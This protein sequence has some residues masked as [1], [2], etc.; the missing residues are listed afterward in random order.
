MR[1]GL[2]IDVFFVVLFL[3]FLLVA[4][5]IDLKRYYLLDILTLPLLWLGL[6]ANLDA[7]F[8]LINEAVLGAVA[9]Y[10]SLALLSA[11]VSPIINRR[12][13]GEG[14][15]KLLAALGAW[16]GW[17]MLPFVLFTASIIALFF[18]AVKSF[19]RGRGG[20]QIPFGPCLSVAA[21]IMLFYGN[22]IILYYWD[23]VWG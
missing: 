6:L 11:A 19:V 20:R 7:R 2:N 4:S 17:Q 13:M 14:D 5:I 15:F 18:S 23:F 21:I 10:L 3:S 22:E 8:V 12:A 9:G 1:F 16:L